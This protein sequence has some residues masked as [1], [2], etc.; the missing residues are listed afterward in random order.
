MNNGGEGRIKE[1]SLVGFEPHISIIFYLVL[2]FIKSNV[3]CS[4]TLV[5]R[6]KYDSKEISIVI[7]EMFV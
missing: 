7:S 6:I 4:E 3:V 2:P 1:E 5:V